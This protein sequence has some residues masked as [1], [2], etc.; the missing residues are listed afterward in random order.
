MEQA[1]PGQ[2]RPEPPVISLEDMRKQFQ[3]GP[4]V[5]LYEPAGKKEGGQAGIGEKR[6]H[7]IIIITIG[8]ACSCNSN[9]I[10]K[11][12]EPTPTNPA[13]NPD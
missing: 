11:R 9:H 8:Q 7:T 1:K 6:K 10:H 2:A 5:T 3:S 12:K 4:H 13:T